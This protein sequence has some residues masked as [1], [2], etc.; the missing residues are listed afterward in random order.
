[1][2]DFT[3]ILAS[4]SPRRRELLSMLGID[5]KIIVS[6]CDEN[7]DT[8]LS[9]A[10]IVKELAQRKAQAVAEKYDGE[11]DYVIL[12]SD[13][14]VAID[15]K[16]LG[17]PHSE[18]EA[19]EMLET[20]SGREHSVFTGVALS[21]RFDGKIKIAADTVETKVRFG[22]M[23]EGEIDYYIRSGEPMDKAGAY[24]I[25]GIGGFF[26]KA[27]DGDYYNV[28]GLPIFKMKEMLSGEFGIDPDEYLGG[29]KCQ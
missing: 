28:V 12:G 3:F 10:D 15:G 23:T 18:K 17:K 26:V 1:M 25:Q 11:G 21:A 8:P 7:I 16:I 6:N 27:I 29:G 20:L 14:V 19:R 2:M 4:N 13:T 24:G 22:H 5:F 9:P